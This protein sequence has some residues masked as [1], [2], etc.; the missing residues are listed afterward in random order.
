MLFAAYCF[1]KN[2]RDKKMQLYIKELVEELGDDVEAN[3]IRN[4]LHMTKDGKKESIK[5]KFKSWLGM[6]QKLGSKEGTKSGSK[7]GT[8]S[9]SKEATKSGSKEATKS[10]SKEGIKQSKS[11]EKVLSFLNIISNSKEQTSKS[12]TV[13]S[14]SKG[15]ATQKKS[16]SK[17]QSSSST[18]ATTLTGS[19]SYSKESRAKKLKKPINGKNSKPFNQM[20]RGGKNWKDLV[21]GKKPK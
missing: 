12:K 17:E 7:E 10:G 8:K 16:G 1:E 11:K 21:A 6:K 4:E 14:T 18:A 15:S 20:Q 3:Q 13:H 5:A 9:G 19:T 2:R